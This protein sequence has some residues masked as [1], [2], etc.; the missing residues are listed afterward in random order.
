MSDEKD[1]DKDQQKFSYRPDIEYQDTY[2][3][4]HQDQGFTTVTSG[5]RTDDDKGKDIIDN[6]TKTFNE[7][8]KVIP[9]IPADLQT[10]VNGVYKPILDS[11]ASFPKKNYPK[12]IP[13][14]DKPIWHPPTER[15]PEPDPSKIIH[16]IPPEWPEPDPPTYPEPSQIIN[17]GGIWDI[18][19]PIG[20]GFVTVD[21]VEVIEKEYIKNIADLYDFYVNRLKDILYRYQSEKLTAIYA[22]KIDSKGNLTS[23]TLDDLAFLF[24]PVTG[25][26][27]DI[28]EHSK[29]LF[30]SCISMNERTKLKMNFLANVCPVEQTLLHLKNFNTVYQLRLRYAKID[31]AK[32]SNKINAMNN[33][34]LRALQEGYDLKYDTAFRD[35]YKY[36][37]SSLDILEDVINTDLAGLKARRTLIEKGGIKK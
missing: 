22:R 29:H 27:S 14:K 30:D 17:G 11:W 7:V 6:I 18:D 35:L 37:N 1:K 2:E 26:C 10:V 24:T 23:K 4:E 21:P 31:T 25:N 9:L 34:I 8:T 15:E 5:D 12:T 16:P 32:E 19:V 28:E 33:R 20:S 13:E 36:L 3:S